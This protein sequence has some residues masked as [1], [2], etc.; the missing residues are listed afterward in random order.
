MRNKVFAAKSKLKSSAGES[1]PRLAITES[2]T[3]RRLTLVEEAREII[4]FR[5]VW[6][7]KGL[8]YCEFMGQ[9]HYI[10]D[11]RISINELNLN[12]TH[13]DL[14]PNQT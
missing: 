1:N 11:F 9:R 10:D 3:K 8:V 4:E 5:N 7:Q 13:Q 12:L 6:T 14:R 2:L